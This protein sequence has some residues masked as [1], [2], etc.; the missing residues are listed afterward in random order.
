ME[1][2][3]AH[4]Q[5]RPAR[6]RCVE[7]GTNICGACRVKLGGRNYCRPCVPERLQK[8][9]PGRRSPTVAAVLSAVP[10]LGQM[11]AGS[12]SRGLVF[13]LSAGALAANLQTVPDPVPLFL[14]VFNLFDAYL[15]AGERNVRLIGQD[16]DRSAVRQKR[17]WGLFAAG[18]AAFCAIRSTVNPDLSPDLLWPG[19]LALY[20][21]FILFDR[22]SG[23]VQPA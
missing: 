10:G 7:C 13:L 8:K 9:M 21:L 2:C 17:Y 11:Y 5:T 18:T 4:H 23:D 22:R 15:Q 3:C 20:G 16:P 14:W 12:F 6:A 1:L 19:A